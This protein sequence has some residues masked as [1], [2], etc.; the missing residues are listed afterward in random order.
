MTV[1]PE[2]KYLEALKKEAEKRFNWKR[3]FRI[4]SS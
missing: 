3:C 2:S 4:L 1:Y